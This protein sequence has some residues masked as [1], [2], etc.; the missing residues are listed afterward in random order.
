MFVWAGYH[1]APRL[2]RFL[3]FCRQCIGQFIFDI[4]DVRVGIYEE[5]DNDAGDRRENEHQADAAAGDPTGI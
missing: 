5:G 3:W 2:I 4:A 1:P